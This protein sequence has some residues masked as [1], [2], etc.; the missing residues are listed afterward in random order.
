MKIIL[1]RIII[2]PANKAQTEKTAIMYNENDSKISEMNTHYSFFTNKYTLT[3]EMCAELEVVRLDV[4][5]LY[6]GITLWFVLIVCLSS[7]SD[8]VPSFSDA[9]YGYFSNPSVGTILEFSGVTGIT[10]VPPVVAVICLIKVF[11]K[12][13][14]EKQFK[15]HMKL[16]PSAERTLSFY[17]EHVILQGKFSRKLPYRELKRVGQTKHYYILFFTEKRIVPVDKN[18]FRKGNLKELKV[19]LRKK[20]TWKSKIY[21]VVRYVPLVVLFAFFC[22]LLWMQ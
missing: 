20:R 15:E 6:V 22:Y 16:V 21:G 13:V 5:F 19:F 8:I 17:D 7:A 3:K 12:L 18:G 10:F 11:P 14:G 9:V 2:I 1:A 4:G